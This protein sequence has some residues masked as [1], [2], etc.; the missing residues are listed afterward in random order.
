MTA[1]QGTFSGGEPPVETSNDIQV[2]DDG[3][4]GWKDKTGALTYLLKEA[5]VGKFFRSNSIAIDA[6]EQ[7]LWYESEA[8]GPV[9]APLAMSIPVVTGEAIVGE[10]LTCSEP[11]VTG[12]SG[13]YEFTYTWKLVES[14]GVTFAQGQVVVVP[15]GVV[16]KEGYCEVTATDATADQAISKDSNVVGPVVAARDGIIVTSAAHW[17]NLN[18]Y[19]EGKT[20]FAE[21]AAFVGGTEGTVIYRYR[22][23]TRAS[24]SDSWINGSWKSY[25]DH[26]LEVESPVLG[27]GDIRFQ[28]QARDDSVDPAEQVNSFTG[29]ESITPL[30]TTIGTVTV[31]V[32][33]EVYDWENP[34]TLT[35]LMND[36]IDIVTTISGDASPIY[37][38]T[39]RDQNL[40]YEIQPPFIDGNKDKGNGPDITYTCLSEGFHAV[41][42]SISDRTATDDG[43]SFP[44]VQL[45]AVDAKTWAELQAKK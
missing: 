15:P 4:S 30:P 19:T 23:Q 24:S 20:V 10:T 34:A 31:T 22:W 11:S 27:T 8:I 18:D 42:I 7:E 25:T 38:Y 14:S 3:I 16:G 12:G 35:V 9:T 17:S 6:I 33:G 45:W 39:T 21:C 1:T 43:V 37:K 40:A 32:L 2:S 41:S 26:A 36:P 44:G 29:V 28:C 13:E 5:D